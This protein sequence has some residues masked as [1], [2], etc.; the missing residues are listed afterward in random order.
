MEIKV[1]DCNRTSQVINFAKDLY[2]FEQLNLVGD[3]LSLTRKARGNLHQFRTLKY[4]YLKRYVTQTLC[5]GNIKSLC[6]TNFILL[7]GRRLNKRA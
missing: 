7:H 5:T 1:L 4:D 3:P 6:S 2:S